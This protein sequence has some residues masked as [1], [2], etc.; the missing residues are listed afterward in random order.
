LTRSLGQVALASFSNPGG[1]STNGGNIYTTSLNSG[2]P[3]VGAAT[4][5]GRGQISAGFLEQSNVDLS[6]DLT[7]MIVTQRAFESNTKIVTTVDTMLQDL[8]DMKR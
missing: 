3:D 4:T 5:G 6:T 8:L 1:L 2:L 7:N